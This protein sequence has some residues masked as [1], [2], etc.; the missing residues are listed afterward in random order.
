MFE[1]GRVKTR[2]LLMKDE[3]ILG[4]CEAYFFLPIQTC[5]GYIAV[6]GSRLLFASLAGD[7]KIGDNYIAAFGLNEIEEIQW[8]PRDE[9]FPLLS[10]ISF[11]YNGLTHRAM[12]AG[13]GVRFAWVENFKNRLSE[14][15]SKFNGDS[16]PGISGEVVKD[17]DA[18][19]ALKKIPVEESVLKKQR[20]SKQKSYFFKIG[21]ILLLG[22][23]MS[24]CSLDTGPDCGGLD[25]S[26][27]PV[28]REVYDDFREQYYKDQLNP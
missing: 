16:S 13:E 1:Y 5:F 2:S 24:R 22:W 4:D 28:C 6:T 12:F 18:T 23:L 9:A 19:F 21:S 15:L 11:K 10:S 3:Q 8:M 20:S 25:S 26:D 17:I 14:N 7:H 27:D